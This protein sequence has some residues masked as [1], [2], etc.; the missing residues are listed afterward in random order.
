MSSTSSLIKIPVETLRRYHFFFLYTN[1]QIFIIVILHKFLLSSFYK[2]YDVL[3]LF[4]NVE[5]GLVMYL[6]QGN[7]NLKKKGKKKFHRNLY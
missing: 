4:L 6:C 7:A 1:E 5:N 3:I 2:F